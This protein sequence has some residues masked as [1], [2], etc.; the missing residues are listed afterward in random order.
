M[1]KRVHT[2]EYYEIETNQNLDNRV[3]VGSG[4]DAKERKKE[5][6]EKE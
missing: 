3:Q 6:K 1:S 4:S 5:K 2:K